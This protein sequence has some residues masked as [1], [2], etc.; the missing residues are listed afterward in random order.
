MWV[1]NAVSSNGKFLPMLFSF[2]WP[3][4]LVA[5]VV[6]NHCQVH[7]EK[8][9]FALVQREPFCR[10]YLL[11]KALDF[12]CSTAV[13]STVLLS[14]KDLC[15]IYFSRSCFVSAWQLQAYLF[16]LV[17]VAIEQG[18]EKK[19]TEAQKIALPRSI[20][21]GRPSFWHRFARKNCFGGKKS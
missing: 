20:H 19:N 8:L 2:G 6:P 1:Q 16:P 15:F 14:T 9:P 3:N 11:H 17:F 13:R 5:V 4:G 10:L 12:T 7:W 21:R 18:K